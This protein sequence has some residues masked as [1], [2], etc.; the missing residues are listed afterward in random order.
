MNLLL[1]MMVPGSPFKTQKKE[2]YNYLKGVLK[3][4]AFKELKTVAQFVSLQYS[5]FMKTDMSCKYGSRGAVV[6]TSQCDGGVK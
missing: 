1:S 2:Y 3:S 4:S 6:V 5:C